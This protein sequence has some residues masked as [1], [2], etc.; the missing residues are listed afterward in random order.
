MV[1]LSKQS[2][3]SK[4]TEEYIITY[5]NREPA[6]KHLLFNSLGFRIFIFTF[7]VKCFSVIATDTTLSLVS[8]W[9]RNG[10]LQGKVKCF[11]GVVRMARVA[12]VHR[13]LLCLRVSGCWLNRST[14]VRPEGDSRWVDVWRCCDGLTVL[15][16]L[17]FVPFKSFT[18]VG[19][20]DIALNSTQ[21]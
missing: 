1:L 10:G 7:Y 11:T 5:E 2:S 4:R 8:Y 17:A 6:Q 16:D 18:V 21:R 15:F 19:D 3:T 13:R 14:E 20:F 9:R 12:R